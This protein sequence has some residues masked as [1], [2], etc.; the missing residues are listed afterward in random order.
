MLGVSRQVGYKYLAHKDRPWKY[1]DLADAMRA[2]HTEDECND[3]HGRIRMYQVLLLKNPE[4]LKIPCER[5][6]V[7]RGMDEIGLKNV[8]RMVLPWMIGKLVSQII[9]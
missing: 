7:Y 3:T 8:S 1:Q 4:G 2:I 6:T 5:T 9:F